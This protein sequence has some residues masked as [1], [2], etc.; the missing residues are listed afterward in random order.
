M[1]Y[2]IWH[3]KEA[4]KKTAFV[5]DKGKWVFCSLLYGINIGHSAFSYILGKVLAQC[6]EFALNYLDNIMIFSKTWK[7]H[8]EHL[9]EVFKWLEAA[10]LKIKCSEWE[11]FKTRVHYL[12]FI[13]GVQ[14]LPQKVVMRQTL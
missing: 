14:Q 8:L 5:I 7:E 10:Y 3:T 2:H 6:T 12:H 4:A 1:Y 9:E 11:L 13:I